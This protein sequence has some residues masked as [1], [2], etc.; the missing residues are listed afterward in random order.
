MT[1]E[2]W[3]HTSKIF[4]LCYVITHSFVLY[5]WINL[6]SLCDVLTSYIGYLGNTCSLGY[7]S[8]PNVD[9]FR[10]TISK[11]I[12]FDIII[13]FIRWKYCETIKLTVVD[14]VFW[15]FNF[16]FIIGNKFCHFFSTKYPG[17]HHSFWCEKCHKLRYK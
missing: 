12:Y 11:A 14:T 1:S 9:T 13:N 15:N 17:S 5:F 3:Y 6:L 16:C 8:L 2:I 4:V 7:A 10:Y